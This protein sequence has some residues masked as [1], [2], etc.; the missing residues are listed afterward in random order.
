MIKKANV[1]YSIMMSVLIFIA[2]I[3]FINPIKENIDIGRTNL[4]CTSPD[5]TIGEEATC[6]ATGWYLFAF[7][8]AGLAISTAYL[9][10]RI[11]K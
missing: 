2:V 4:N 3:S 8:M 9:S 6:L 7:V 5:L 1:F 10:W 11:G